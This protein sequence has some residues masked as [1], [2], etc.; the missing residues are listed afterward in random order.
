MTRLNRTFFAFRLVAAVT[1][2]TFMASTTASACT[3]ILLKNADGTIVHGRTL[4]FGV[5]VMIDFAVQPR[6]YSFTGSTPL[7]DGKKWTTKY[8]AL[9]A[10]AFGNLGIMDGIN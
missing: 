10:I 2:T 8:G 7:G 5:P 6:G 3:G 9:G 1:A 4:E